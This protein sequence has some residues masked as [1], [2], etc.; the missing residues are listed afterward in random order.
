MEEGL[1]FLGRFF[2]DVQK[3]K[4]GR[5]FDI[6]YSICN[7]FRGADFGDTLEVYAILIWSFHCRYYNQIS[8][9]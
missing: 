9:F 6:K 2:A 4:F 3:H 7:F 1:I 5:C 8:V